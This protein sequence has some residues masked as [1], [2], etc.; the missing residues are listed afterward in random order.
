MQSALIANVADFAGIDHLDASARM[1][2]I[3]RNTMPGYGELL[4]II[5]DPA[6]GVAMSAAQTLL[7]FEVCKISIVFG[8]VSSPFPAPTTYGMCARTCASLA[9][10]NA[11]RRIP[12]SALR[13]PP[14]T[15]YIPPTL[16]PSAALAPAR[17]VWGGGGCYIMTITSDC[18]YVRTYVFQQC[19][20]AYMRA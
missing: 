18:L 1:N 11:V 19:M 3:G 6:V 13:P 8:P 2:I 14:T 10:Q 9:D 5:L 16:A 17:A 12:P 20:S 4:E 7:D 15:P